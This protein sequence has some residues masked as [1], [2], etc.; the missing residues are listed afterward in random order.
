MTA[1]FKRVAG[2]CIAAQLLAG[3]AAAGEVDLLDHF[4]DKSEILSDSPGQVLRMDVDV[5][6]DGDPE[7]FLANSQKMGTSGIQEWFVYSRIE[8]DRYK[9]LGV[10]AFSYRLFLVTGDGPR[11]VAYYHD[12]GPMG[13]VVTYRVT[14]SGFQ[15]ESTEEN[16]A[17]DA[18]ASEF[19]SWR[20]QVG[21]KVLAAGL[22]EL[23]GASAPDWKD[24]LTREPASGVRSLEGLV[25]V[26]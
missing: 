5:T 18:H 3:C 21:L 20:N 2:I 25:V 24:L 17:A 12:V 10:L 15:Q 4:W 9:P 8:S 6:G 13:S 19:A 11:L 7:I 14:A 1:R 22:N 16:V 26:E 23:N